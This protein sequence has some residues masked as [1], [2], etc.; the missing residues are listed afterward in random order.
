[1]TAVLT[2]YVQQKIANREPFYLSPEI[3]SDTVDASG[4]G[5]G[6]WPIVAAIAAFAVKAA[7]VIIGVAGAKAGID[8]AKAN[9]KAASAAQLQA[10]ADAD[11]AAAALK[12]QQ[13]Q[14]PA[15]VMPQA[16]SAARQDIFG[17]V[18]KNLLFAGAAALVALL[19]LK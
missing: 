19:L 6:F 10:K 13:M 12:A 11:A 3:N 1:M 9:K 17:G 7:P 2:D 14:T 16:L 8:T 5:F 15:A 18:D 4:K